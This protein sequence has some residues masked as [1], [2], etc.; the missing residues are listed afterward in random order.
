MS[1]LSDYLDSIGHPRILVFGDLILDRYT[2]GNA[3]RISPEAP[4]VVLKADSHEARLGGAASVAGLL[5]TLGAEVVLAGVIGDDA[6]GRVLRRLLSDAGIDHRLVL[7]DPNRPTTTKERFIGR[8]AGRHPHQILRVDDEV[9]TPLDVELQSELL[10]RILERLPEFQAVLISDY[11][12]GV[13]RAAEGQGP[14]DK[15]GRHPACRLPQNQAE[16]E[17]EGQGLRAKG[18]N[19]STDEADTRR[20][21]QVFGA[22]RRQPPGGPGVHPSLLRWGLLH[23]VLRAAE[24]RGIP[25]IVDP[26]RLTDYSGYD[27]ALVLKPNRIEAELASGIRIVTPDDAIRAGD[28]LCQRLGLQAAVITLDCDGMV[29]CQ[30]GQPGRLFP[31][32]TREVY[33]ITG[34]GDMGL[35]MLGLVL[36]NPAPHVYPKPGTPLPLDITAALPDAVR[37]ANVAA[38]LEVQ[39]WGVAPISRDEIRAEL[40]A[41]S[42]AGGKIVVGLDELAALAKRYRRDNKTI[43]VT[44]GCFDL[45]HVGHISLLE[46]AARLGDVLIVAINSD[47]SVRKLKGS[48]RPI[49]GQDDRTRM[50]AALASVDHVLIFDDDTPHRL[51]AAISPDVLA[52][53][54]T[55]GDIVGREIVEA[56]GGTI[57]R[58]PIVPGLSTT[59]LVSRLQSSKPQPVLSETP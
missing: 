12:K 28:L 48:E 53:G 17:A 24:D 19:E 13:C 8:A 36:A 44:N 5:S 56:Y 42:G 22:R 47:A 4:V 49:I 57:V 43:V 2:S 52:K 16:A 38:G 10:D 1:L 29:L 27:G 26:A 30:P 15:W 46:E 54:G 20:P 45:L 31:T 6:N 3:D 11:D 41:Q 32:Q 51:L 14:G 25:V 21:D 34:A 7:C 55:T 33:D 50:L 40:L 37:L 35:A 18:Q 39:R 23:I 9:R 58:T 59:N